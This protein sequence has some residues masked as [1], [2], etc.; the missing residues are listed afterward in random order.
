MESQRTEGNPC[1]L[2]PPAIF[3]C[4]LTPIP[5]VTDLVPKQTGSCRGFAVLEPLVK[6]KPFAF[7]LIPWVEVDWREGLCLGGHGEVLWQG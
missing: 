1:F 3:S 4:Q 5:S 6:G 7:P 2:Q